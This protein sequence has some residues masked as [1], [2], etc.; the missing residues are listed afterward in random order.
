[1]S[2]PDLRQG[3]DAIGGRAEAL[4]ERL[5]RALASAG[6]RITGD[7]A[8]GKQLARLGT[9]KELDGERFRR[10]D[11]LV[12][13]LQHGAGAYAAVIGK[14]LRRVAARIR[15]EAEDIAAE[16]QHLRKPAGSKE[17]PHSAA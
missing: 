16:A 3:R 17:P 8:V 10:A 15:E 13:R 14:R 5:G 7:G 6:S 12:T 11:Q 1:M 2:S 4:G 9:G